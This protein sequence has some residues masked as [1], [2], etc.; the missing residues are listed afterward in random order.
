[1]A[2][3]SMLGW[4]KDQYTKVPPVVKVDLSGK[5]VI[6]VGANTGIGYEAAK[7]FALMNPGR[8]IMACRSK[9]RGQAAVDSNSFL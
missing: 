6:V 3:K 9:E 8:L 7:H 1:M 5:T 2:K 4:A